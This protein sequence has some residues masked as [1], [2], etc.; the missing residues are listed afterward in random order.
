MLR[1]K[2]KKKRIYR[3]NQAG[4]HL[5][6]RL[7]QK[8]DR[9]QRTNAAFGTCQEMGEP[10]PFCPLFGMPQLRVGRLGRNRACTA[11]GRYWIS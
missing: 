9:Y 8:Y 10:D 11:C 5:C 1:L 7:L 2:P 4:T 6:W 3:E